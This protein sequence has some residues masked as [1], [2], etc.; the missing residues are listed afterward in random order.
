[1]LNASNRPTKNVPLETA[2]A[3]SG[4]LQR[5]LSFR[6]GISESR[7]S[8]IKKAAGR[9]PTES[10][11]ARLA[12]ALST[13]VQLLFPPADMVYVEKGGGAAATSPRAEAAATAAVVEKYLTDSTVDWQNHQTERFSLIAAFLQLRHAAGLDKIR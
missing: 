2:I 7:L 9:P 5:D 8:D 1:M 3:I 11:K 4:L 13:P 6:T 10:E 12:Q